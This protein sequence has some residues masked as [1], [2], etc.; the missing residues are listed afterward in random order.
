MTPQLTKHC[1][2]DL[3]MVVDRVDT[4]FQNCRAACPPDDAPAEQ[5][6]RWEGAFMT[7]RGLLTEELQP[8]LAAWR[9]GESYSHAAEVDRGAVPAGVAR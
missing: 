5:V 1:I 9:A 2:M 3:E 7:L 8:L 6:A 4:L